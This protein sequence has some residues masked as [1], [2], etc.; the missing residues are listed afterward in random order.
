MV[1][2]LKPVRANEMH[3][4]A[5]PRTKLA[6]EDCVLF[7]SL[8]YEIYRKPNKGLQNYLWPS[9]SIQGLKWSF[10]NFGLF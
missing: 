1:V 9:F 6:L 10:V 2:G 5:E 3:P 8:Q 4:I 7:Q